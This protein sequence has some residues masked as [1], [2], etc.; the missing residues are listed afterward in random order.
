MQFPRR[1]LDLRPLVLP[2]LP[3]GGESRPAVT[4]SCPACPQVE[5]FEEGDHITSYIESHNNPYNHRLSELGSGLMLQVR[6]VCGGEGL[7]WSIYWC[8]GTQSL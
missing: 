7:P 5:S 8:M 6:C 4:L 2:R 1:R 3:S